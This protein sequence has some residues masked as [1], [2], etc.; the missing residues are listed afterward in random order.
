MTVGASMAVAIPA[1]AGADAHRVTAGRRLRPV[2]NGALFAAVLLAG[3]TASSAQSLS[4]G[5]V[6][7]VIGNERYESVASLANPVQDARAMA[8]LLRDLGF[9][10]YD[11]YDLDRQGFETLL[12]T[13]MLNAEPEDEV[14]FFFAGHGIQIGQRN[15]LLPVDARF[16]DVHDLPKYAITLDRV[17]DALA[18]RSSAHVAIIDACREN[19]F[20]DQMLA[21]GL[22]ASLYEAR[23]GFQVLRTPLNSLVA[24][25]ASPGALALDGEE[26]GHSP[27]TDA[28]LAS[29]RIAPDENLPNLLAQVR[30]AVYAATA[31]FQVPWE[32]STLVRPFVLQRTATAAV[33]ADAG[34]ARRRRPTCPRR[35]APRWR[36]R[37]RPR[38]RP[39]PSRSR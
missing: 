33:P 31:G 30:Q 10:V 25:S 18:A 23:D 21:A 26:G 37:L 19:P 9:R 24:F 14:L 34:G 28:L 20:P 4:A 27:F 32:S 5:G 2:R 39:T 1:A 22:D 8:T 6:A 16:Q 29:A 36:S 35:R 3:A 15:Y 7:L 11:G 12:R 13:A 17:V 38:P